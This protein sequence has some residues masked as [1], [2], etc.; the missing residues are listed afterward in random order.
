MARTLK[1]VAH[2]AQSGVY[3]PV[4][5]SLSLSHTNTH[6]HAHAHT[7]FDVLL[8][9]SPHSPT[10]TRYLFFFFDKN[11]ENCLWGSHQCVATA[12]T[13]LNSSHSRTNGYCGLVIIMKNIE[14][15]EFRKNKQKISN[16]KK[17]SDRNEVHFVLH[18]RYFKTIDLFYY[19]HHNLE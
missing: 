9:R 5:L 3:V 18:T 16:G 4:S 8:E 6:A 12:N 10:A 19:Q 13:T 7:H 11:A 17:Q 1:K 15:K 14:R 2:A